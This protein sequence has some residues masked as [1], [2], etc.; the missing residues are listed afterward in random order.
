VGANVKSMD[1]YH[2]NVNLFVSVVPSVP[3][4]LNAT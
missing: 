1:E 2:S 3:T 4:S